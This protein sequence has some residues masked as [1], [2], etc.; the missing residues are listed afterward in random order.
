MV[1][2]QATKENITTQI[3]K[4]FKVYVRNSGVTRGGDREA[5]PPLE[6]FETAVNVYVS[7]T[8]RNLKKD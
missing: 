7:F 4:N 5:Q 8:E 3:L 6:N 1:N 2:K